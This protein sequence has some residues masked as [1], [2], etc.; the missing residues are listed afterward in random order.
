M[1][2]VCFVIVSVLLLAVYAIVDAATSGAGFGCG[3]TFGSSPC[4]GAVAEYV[5]LV[6]ALILLAVGAVFLVVVF[7]D[8]R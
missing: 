8:I 3:S 5:F 2:G 6:P 4:A 1:L 7:L